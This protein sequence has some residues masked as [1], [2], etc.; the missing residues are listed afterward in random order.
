MSAAHV[1]PCRRGHAKKH[2]SVSNVTTR[3]GK[4]TVRNYCVKCSTEGRRRWDAANP[5]KARIVRKNARMKNTGKQREYHRR[6]RER[7]KAAA[8]SS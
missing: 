5:E 7:R 3:H 1:K 2:I 4:R 8:C 6:W